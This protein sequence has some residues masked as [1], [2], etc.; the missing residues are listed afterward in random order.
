MRIFAALLIVLMLLLGVQKTPE[1]QVGEIAVAVGVAAT[2][3]IIGGCVSAAIMT[4]PDAAPTAPAIEQAPAVEPQRHEQK[5]SRHRG[6][7]P[8]AAFLFLYLL[9]YA[10]EERAGLRSD[11]AGLFKAVAL[12]EA[13]H[14]GDRLRAVVAGLILRRE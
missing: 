6:F 1:A 9:G 2:G 10:V 11:E 5:E 12:L 3:A 7:I 8:M 4:R 13:P 14:R